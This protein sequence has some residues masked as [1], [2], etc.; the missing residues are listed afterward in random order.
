MPEGACRVRRSNARKRLPDCPLAHDAGI[1]SYFVALTSHGVALPTP[2]SS[3]L[4]LR[5]NAMPHSRPKKRELSR[6]KSLI[7]P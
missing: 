7:F 1:Q 5:S 3:H 2:I 6:L 4:N